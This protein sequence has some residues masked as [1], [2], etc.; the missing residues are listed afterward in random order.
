M[1]KAL[2]GMIKVSILYY[3]KFRTDI[4]SIGYLVNP[5]DACVANKIINGKQHTLTWHVN[6]VKASHVDAKVND[7]FHKWCESKYGSEKLGH[8]TVIRGNKHDS[9][10]MNLDYSDKGKLKIDMQ[11]YIDNMDEEPV[12]T[13]LWNEKLF[14]VVESVEPLNEE[15]KALLHT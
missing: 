10:V 8:V 15:K 11:Y 5:Y 7:Q 6:D 12:T 2:Y 1:L 14:K 13:T 3:K 9:L 4:E